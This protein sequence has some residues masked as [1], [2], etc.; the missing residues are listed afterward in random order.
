MKQPVK[1]LLMSCLLPY[2]AFAVAATPP[3]M[4]APKAG[5]A[6]I[7]GK[8][9]AGSAPITIYDT[10]YPAKTALGSGKSMDS[11]G[12]FAVVV[13]PKLISGHTLIAVDAKGQTSQ[14]VVVGVP[15]GPAA[16]PAK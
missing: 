10:S 6:T 16:G 2:A 3:V 7:S 14:P 8:A 9:Q 4:N 12:N 5:S 1:I 15:A 13:S 11:A